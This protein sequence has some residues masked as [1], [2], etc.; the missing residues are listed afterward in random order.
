MPHGRV[1]ATPNTRAEAERRARTPGARAV[2]YNHSPA[3]D[4][5]ARSRYAGALTHYDGP[6][7]GASRHAHGRRTVFI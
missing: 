3:A 4:A 2:S 6:H 5:L 1:R 7:G